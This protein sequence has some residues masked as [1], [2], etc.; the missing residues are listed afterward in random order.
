MKRLCIMG[1]ICSVMLSTPVVVTAAEPTC[2]IGNCNIGECFMDADGDG[3]CDSHCFIDENDD[4]ICDNHCYM[5]EDGDGVCDHFTD[6]DSDGIC[7]HC[8]EHG[9]PVKTVR[10]RRTGYGR[11]HTSRHSGHHKGHC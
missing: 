3:M 8:H 5:D 1:I 6:E 9:K 4:G 10:S 11:H 2:S 7:D